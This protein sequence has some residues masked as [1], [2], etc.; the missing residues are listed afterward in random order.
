MRSRRVLV[1]V[2]AMSALLPIASVL[3]CAGRKATTVAEAPSKTAS[4]TFVE[5]G[6]LISD[7][8]RLEPVAPGASRRAY[9]NPDTKLSMYEKLFL[10]RVTLWR[11]DDQ[12]EP[13]DSIDYQRLVDDLHAVA[14]RELGK[15]FEL[16]DAPGPGIARLRVALVAIDDPDDRLDVFV[17]Q[18]KPSAVRSNDALPAGLRLFVGESWV[19]AEILDAPSD[20]PLLAVVDRIADVMPHSKPIETWSDLHEA[21]DAWAVQ[22]SKRIA[23]VANQ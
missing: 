17:S 22:A 3:S 1:A 10:D 19:E 6:F 11:D 2:L 8:S 15:T 12:Q 7:Y 16:V 23:E 9:V 4:D 5:S 20:T 14:A 13:V 21:F 18:G